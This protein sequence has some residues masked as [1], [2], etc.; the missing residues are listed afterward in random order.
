MLELTARKATRNRLRHLPTLSLL[1]ITSCGLAMNSEDRLNRAEE[2]LENGEYRAAIIDAK[3]VL[4]KEPDNVRGRLLLGRA[5]IRINDAAAAEKEFR[6]ALELG[7]DPVLVAVD[8]GHALLALR[9]F[10]SVIEEIRPDLAASDEGLREIYKL[11]G[12]ALLGLRRPDEARAVFSQILE[13]DADDVGAQLGMVSSY[14]IEQNFVQARATLDHVLMDNAD[15]VEPWLASGQLYFD[16]RN[17]ELAEKHFDKAL[18]LALETAES[19]A[20][21]RALIGLGNALLAQDKTDSARDIIERLVA[22]SANMPQT[23]QLSARVAYI[24]KDWE[25]AQSLLQEV[26][27]RLPDYRP[28][29]LLLGAVHLQNGN[30]ELAEMYLSAVVAAVPANADARNLLAQT[31]LQQR[32]TRA[33]QE[34]LQPILDGSVPN[35]NSLALAT[36]ASLGAGDLE[37]AARYLEQLVQVSPDKPVTQLDLAAVYLMADRVGDAQAILG[38]GSFEESDANNFRRDMLSVLSFVRAQ[39]MAAARIEARSATEKWPENSRAF[40]LLGSV[41]VLGGDAAAARESFT[42]AA[43]LAPNDHLPLRFLA[44]VE[45]D[46]GDYVEARNRFLQVVEIVPNDLASLIALARLSSRAD[47]IGGAQHWLERAVAADPQ[48]FK[49]R[50]ILGQILLALRDFEAARD[51][52][53]ESIRI[54][55]TDAESHRLLGHALL[56]LDETGP[57]QD[58]FEEAISL[59]PANSEYWFSLARTRIAAGDRDAAVR[60]IDEAYAENPQDIKI[61][62]MQA[63]SKINNKDLDAAMI[64]AKDLRMAHPGSAV[65]ISLEAEVLAHKGQMS[66]AAGLYDQV[67]ALDNAPR[68]AARAYQL[69]NAAG[70]PNKDEPLRKHLEQYPLNTTIRVFLAQI[71]QVDGND[72]DAVSEYQR[73]LEIAPDDPIALNNLA[74]MYFVS[75]DSRARELA[76]KAYVIAPENSFVVDTLGWI[77]VQQGDVEDGVKLLQVAVERSNNR[78]VI[79]YHLAAG[80]AKLGKNDDARRT[81]E[82]ALREGGEFASREDAEELFLQL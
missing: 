27:R 5:S 80:L 82:Q 21:T 32:D 67:L 33:A 65:P 35:A 58:S 47:D 24:D 29:Q 8:L 77:L 11:H 41:E 61:A 39:D 52:A 78:P 20:E 75:G 45:E 70:L 37:Q 64:I 1:I 72:Q 13:M 68:F 66:D 62:V 74:W 50:N 69:R 71:Y 46:G 38:T 55:N 53:E 73:V 9:Q 18:T 49:V 10:E 12:D 79:L 81:L 19:F 22:V 56:N 6:R 40:T 42:K 48:N 23:M 44:S 3:D 57:A 4:R 17:S 59:D 43:G 14:I 60:T 51:L 28:A 26:L 76:Q 16:S 2:A 63:S 15:S 7:A 54:S 25:K 30:L 36:R 34:L 31:R